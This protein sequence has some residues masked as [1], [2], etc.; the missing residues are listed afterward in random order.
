MIEYVV[1]TVVRNKAIAKDIYDMTVSAG[2]NLSGARAGQFVQL[3]VPR[4]EHI[5]PRPI[6]LCGIDKENGELR[7]VYQ[8]VGKGTECF[9]H[10]ESGDEL[11]ILV[12]LGNG[13]DIIR[14][15]T[16]IAVVGGGVGVPPMLELVKEIKEK[17]HD[18]DITAFLGFRTNPFLIKDFARL[19]V[20][21]HVAT[22]DG[23]VG[24]KGNVIELM[25][26]LN[27]K[28]EIVYACGPK[29]MLKR[30]SNWAQ[31]NNAMCFVSMEERMACGVGACV[32]CAIPIKSREDDGFQYKKVCKDGPVFNSAEV[33][34]DEQ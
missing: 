5:L 34:W 7:L 23:S 27:F 22:D 18:A 24:F 6:S 11:R 3:F 33:V 32:G 15:K 2:R 10:M 9:S 30:L 25:E 20:K 26:S 13:F 19:G 1:S 4:G 31:E 21:L 16:K 8:V 17:I 29:I 28:C 12:P 14:D